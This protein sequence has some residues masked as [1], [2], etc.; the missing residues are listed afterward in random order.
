[1]PNRHVLRRRGQWRRCLL[2]LGRPLSS[3]SKSTRTVGL[4]PTPSFCVAV[5]YGGYEVTYSHGAWSSG[6]RIDT[7]GFMNSVSCPISTMCAAVDDSGYV[8]MDVAGRWSGQ[9]VDT[10]VIDTNVKDSLESIACPT[11]MFCL[12]VDGGAYAFRYSVSP[13]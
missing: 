8:F 1:M 4:R 10:T 11:S 13:P 3:I 5:D 2:I 7:N 9:H 12:A 6:L